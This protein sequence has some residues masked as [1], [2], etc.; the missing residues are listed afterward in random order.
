MSTLC[1]TLNLQYCTF[2]Y[3]TAH[4]KQLSNFIQVN[5]KYLDWRE[6]SARPVVKTTLMIPSMQEYAIA[7][8]QEAI[9]NY[10]T[11]NE[12]ATAIKIKFENQYPAT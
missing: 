1:S 3:V 5:V 9:T 10:T 7:T 11:E 4:K 8:A 2:I 12:I 6:M